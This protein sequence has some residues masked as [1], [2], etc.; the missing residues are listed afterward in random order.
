MFYPYI[1]V[2]LGAISLTFFC[3]I[4]DNKSSVKALILKM[5]T[6]SLFILT[7]FAS[8]MCNPNP[9]FIGFF[10]LLLMGAVFGLIGDIVLD[11]KIIYQDNIKQSE[12]YTHSGMAVFA[13]GHIFYILAIIFYLGGFNLIALVAA[14]II[15]T[16][17]VLIT[18][19]IMK[20]NYGKFIIEVVLY[21]FLLTYFMTSSIF[22]VIDGFGTSAIILL[23]GSV[24]F[25]A[26]DAVLG[27]TYFN[28][29]D[30]KGIITL[31]HVLYYIA[32]F[33]IPLSILYII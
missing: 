16:A 24:F 8:L 28:N 26:S 10:G 20:F 17:I 23:I 21:T 22:A 1:T 11:L 4:R 19:F 6:S 9:H 2:I 31:N 5:I 29:K 33:L 30:N 18:K 3:I 32:Q 7:A 27:M 14:I 13:I 12:L 15:S 25:L